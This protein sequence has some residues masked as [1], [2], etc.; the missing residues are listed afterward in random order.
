MRRII[1]IVVKDTFKSVQTSVSHPGDQL[2]V[3]QLNNFHSGK[4]SNKYILSVAQ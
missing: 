1:A 3:L 4:L 2:E